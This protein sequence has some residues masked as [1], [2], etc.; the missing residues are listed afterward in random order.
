MTSAGFEQFYKEWLEQEKALLDPLRKLVESE[1]STAEIANLVDACYTHYSKYVDAKIQAARED[2]AYVAAGMW[3]TPLEA[4]FLWMGG[5][6]PTTAIVLA[7]SLM[8]I[9]I[10]N[11]LRKL[12]DG[13]EVPSMAA[14]SAKQLGKLNHMQKKTRDGEDDIS[15]RLAVL[16]MLVA[17]QQMARATTA[18]PPPSE[19]NDLSEVREA[20]E[21]KLVQ[22][23]DLLIE[24]EELR[25]R[26]LR[27]MMQILTPLQAAQYTVAA[28]EMAMAVRKLGDQERE[29]YGRDISPITTGPKTIWELAS[30]GQM[31][32]LQEALQKGV[33]PSAADY[34]GRTALHAAAATGHTDAVTLLIKQGADVNKRDSSGN[35][36]LVAALRGGYGA[37][38]QVM[39]KGGATT[40]TQELGIELCKAAATGDTRYVTN[41]VKHGVDPNAADYAGSTPL[42]YL[43]AEGQPD[44]VEFL[45]QQGADILATDRHGFTPVDEARES[46]SDATLKILEDELARRQDGDNSQESSERESSEE[47]SS[48]PMEGVQGFP[49]ASS[50]NENDAGSTC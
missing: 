34:D 21:P 15:S 20:M 23:R 1:K 2:V 8:G 38:A 9:Q 41:L 4:G 27:E 17:D 18:E 25:L 10:E 3:R 7:Y 49:R 43:A 33:D 14:L 13:I 30:Q 24:S 22:L 37:T 40:D 19:T 28:F 12:L 35:T 6:R 48:T 45:V 44:A 31:S 50:W 26:T 5:W 46:G 39:L 32:E 47:S 11:E 42:H 36:P 16:Q 29:M